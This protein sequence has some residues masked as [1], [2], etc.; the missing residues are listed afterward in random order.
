MSAIVL[1]A[2]APIIAVIFYAVLGFLF[3]GYAEKKTFCMVVA[4]HQVMGIGRSIIYEM[5]LVSIA[6]ASLG[7]GVL[8]AVGAVPSIDAYAFLP[9]D[10]AIQGTLPFQVPLQ[11][12]ACNAQ[13]PLVRLA[14]PCS[15]LS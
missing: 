15:H 13:T 11:A 8:V 9:G 6:V 14:F 4:T 5:I 7:S 1:I 3:G 10:C 2:Y 12:Y